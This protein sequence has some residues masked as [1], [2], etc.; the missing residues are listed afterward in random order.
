MFFGKKRFNFLT[1][2]I[3]YFKIVP[4]A[5]TY[6]TVMAIIS[7][8]T[9]TL[10]IIVTARFL[11]TAITAVGDRSQLHA[12]YP[13]LILLIIISLYHYYT[14]VLGNLVD[15][16]MDNRL[17]RTLAPAVA[18]K[19]ARIKFRYYENQDSLDTMNRAI[20]G[21][22]GKLKEFYDYVTGI[23]RLAAQVAGFLI[24]LSAQ[25][26]WAPF[27]FAV[28]SAPSFIVAYIFGKKQYDNEKELTKIDRKVWYFGK[29]Y[30][31]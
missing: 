15:T 21:F 20:D 1:M 8:L 18:L 22:D 9:P 5:A 2:L 14:S 3:L 6:R 25:L 27:V 13:P 7:A 4:A 29:K 30:F 24:V 23:F 12:V 31:L 10:S 28:A 17:R 16:R 19:K 11:D 26:W